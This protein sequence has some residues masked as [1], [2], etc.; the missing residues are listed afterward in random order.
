LWTE[1]GYKKINYY[2]FPEKNVLENK[3]PFLSVFVLFCDRNRIEREDYPSPQALC[4]GE[5]RTMMVGLNHKCYR[6][7]F[8]NWNNCQ[9]LLFLSLLSLLYI[10]IGRREEKKMNSYP[11]CS[12]SCIDNL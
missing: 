3:S 11:F 5:D 6:V 4:S 12:V 8:H 1:T 9:T 10:T 7:N 2:L